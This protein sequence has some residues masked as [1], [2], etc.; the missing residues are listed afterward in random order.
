MT[1]A[2]LH[3]GSLFTT[4]TPVRVLSQGRKRARVQLVHRLRWNG[5]WFAAGSTRYVPTFAIGTPSSDALVSVG[6]GRFARQDSA[7]GRAA[8]KRWSLEGVKP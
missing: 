5:K 7:S 6:R 4:A 2:W 8:L 3:T 1:R